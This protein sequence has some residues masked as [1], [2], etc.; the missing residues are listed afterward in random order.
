MP[1]PFPFQHIDPQWKGLSIFC[2]LLLGCKPLT[3][4]TWTNK[5]II[6]CT[7]KVLKVIYF[8]QGTT[9]IQMALKP[10]PSRAT[11]KVGF[12]V[13]GCDAPHRRSINNSTPFLNWPSKLPTHTSKWK[14]LLEA[15]FQIFHPPHKRWGW[16][17]GRGPCCMTWR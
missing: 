1:K 8:L 17:T 9:T 16:I 6:F 2:S 4:T 7:P 14:T 12:E 15:I 11:L 5:K 3:P 10:I 13:S